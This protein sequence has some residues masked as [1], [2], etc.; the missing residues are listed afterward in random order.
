MPGMDAA[1]NDY[2]IRVAT[3]ADAE[4]LFRF[5][6]TLLAETSFFVRGPGERARSVGEMREVI[7]RF[8]T[9]PHY[10]LL[11]AWQGAEAVAE[12]VAICGDFSRN[13]YTAT[14]GIG[15]LADHSGRGLGRVLMQELDGFA[16]DLGLRRLELTVMAHNTAARTL[17]KKVGYVEEGTKRDSLFVDGGYVS[18]IMMAKVF[19]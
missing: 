1:V 12:A 11:N 17:Y 19:A 6:E 13:Q 3:T 15:V 7:E 14:V 16:C 9:L 10:L 2:D 5:G 8:D 4:A 18:E